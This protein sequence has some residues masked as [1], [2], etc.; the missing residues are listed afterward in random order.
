M[1]WA[2]WSALRSRIDRIR[3][4]HWL[5]TDPPSIVPVI[6][7]KAV[8]AQVY[9][10]LDYRRLGKWFFFPQTLADAI[11]RIEAR[12]PYLKTL[13]HLYRYWEQ[14]NEHDLVSNRAL[15][16]LD[17]FVAKVMDAPLEDDFDPQR[18]A[19]QI[20]LIGTSAPGLLDIRATPLEANI[21]GV[22]I[23]A[24]VIEQIIAGDFLHRP[25]YADA[26][27]TI[28]ILIL[29]LLLIWLLPRIGAV[30]SVVLAGVATTGVVWGSWYA[31]YQL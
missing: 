12:L 11:D 23:H 19:G 28:Y 14:S 1:R 26:G 5:R 31:R 8:L 7:V 13:C 10:A 4:L 29:G 24:Q 3:K 22:E 25:S 9:K 20:L 17:Q 21:P 15:K 2:L 27:E 18:V 6:R 30:W 16:C